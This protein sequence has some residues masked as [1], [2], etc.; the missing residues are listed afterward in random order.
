MFDRQS[1]THHL[2]ELIQ[3][4]SLGASNVVRA[5]SCAFLAYRCGEQVGLYDVR[6]VAEVASRLAVTE[7]A[8]T[9]VVQ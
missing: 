6:N 5:A 9:L 4:H 1:I 8:A 2:I 3:R 7:N